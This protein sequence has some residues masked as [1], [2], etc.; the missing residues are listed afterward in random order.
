MTVSR[1]VKETQKSYANNRT[2]VEIVETVDKHGQ[3]FFRSAQG[4]KDDQS[5]DWSLAGRHFHA[6]GDES[7]APAVICGSCFGDAFMLAYGSYEISA[8]CVACGASDVVYDG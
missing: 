2:Y 1:A 3:T 5:N 6:S 7:K 4:W 8:I